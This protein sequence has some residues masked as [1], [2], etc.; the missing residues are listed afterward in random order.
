ME[1]FDCFEKIILEKTLETWNNVKIIFSKNE[2][3]TG[4]KIFGNKKCTNRL[5]IS[6]LK[7][8]KKSSNCISV[9]RQQTKSK[10]FLHPEGSHRTFHHRGQP[11]QEE[12]I[13]QN[14]YI[15]YVIRWCVGS[16]AKKKERNIR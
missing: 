13:R 4:I 16:G 7:V 14:I 11:M 2:N 12:D 8:T 1:T 15:I 9:S 3:V 6:K 10:I 5:Y